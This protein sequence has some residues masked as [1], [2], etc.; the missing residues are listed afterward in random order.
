[1]RSSLPHR[2]RPLALLIPFAAVAQQQQQ[3]AP[4]L[5]RPVADRPYTRVR[6]FEVVRYEAPVRAEYLIRTCGIR[7]PFTNELESDLREAGTEENVMSAVR[8]V[9]PKPTATPPVK[10]PE[11]V[12]P[13]P[14]PGPKVGDFRTNPKDGLRYAYIPPGTFRMGCASSD[15]GPCDADE[16]PA[17]DVRITKGFWMGQTEVTTEAYKRFVNA[18]GGSMPDKEPES[19]GRKLNPNW[20]GDSLPMTMVT[21]HNARDYCQWAGMGLPTEAEWEY[22]ARAGTTGAHYADLDQ[23]AWYGNNSGDKIIDTQNIWT[24]DQRN[25]AK[26]IGEN[27]NRPRPVGQKKA[28]AFKLY[29]MLGNVW[30]WTADWYKDKYNS[31]SLEVDPDGPP[32]GESR[33]LRGGSWVINPAYVRAS[34]RNG[35]LPTN[36]NSDFGFRCRGEIRVP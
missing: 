30:E 26:R 23:V 20:S 18:T 28:N 36:R 13:P 14:P 21:W 7:M 32:G 22:A 35:Y 31:D 10:Q 19:V 29:D 1:M 9:A 27:G 25:Y 24:S 8:D 33:V 16:K 15:D 2:F 17:H 4:C 12:N 34:N 3:P 6:L 11:P 5:A